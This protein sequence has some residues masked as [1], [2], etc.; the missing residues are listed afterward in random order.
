[1]PDD[2]PTQRTTSGLDAS[3]RRAGAAA[4]LPL[5]IGESVGPYKLVSVLGSGGFGVVYL[6]ER[7]EPYVQRVALKVLL[8]QPGISGD[9][10]I[11]RFEQERQALALMS[12][13]N[14]AGVLDAGTAQRGY[15]FFVMELVA[16]EPITDYCDRRRLTI[17][18]RLGLFVKVCSAVQHAHSKGV[19]HRDL[20]PS[21]VLVT[22]VQGEAVPKVIDFGV[23]KATIPLLTAKTI[24]TEVGRLIGTPEYMSPE[25]A[26]LTAVDI[27]TRTDVYS[28]GVMLYELLSG[29]LPFDSRSLRAAGYAEIQR[30]IREVDP[31]KPS[32]RLTGL[33]DTAVEVAERRRQGRDQLHR[34]LAREL[35]WIP[36][37]AMRKEREHRY[38]TPT[39]LADDIEN[40][41]AGRPLAAG[42][43]S[44]GYRLRKFVRRNRVVV[45]VGGVIAAVLVAATG[46]SL[47]FAASEARARLA[48]DQ[49]RAEA[50]AVRDFLTEDL[51]SPA[52]PE[53]DRP[54][55]PV[56]EL[57]DRA[58][59]DVGEKFKSQPAIEQRLRE[60]LGR[61]YLGI[62]LPDR[63]RVQLERARALI[64]PGAEDAQRRTDEIDG[65]MG[66][67][68]YRLDRAGEAIPLLEPVAARMRVSPGPSDPQTLIVLNQLAGAYKWAG[69]LDDAGKLY[70]EVVDGR[71]RTLGPRHIDTIIARKNLALVTFRTAV[72]GSKIASDGRIESGAEGFE[73]ALAEYRAIE[74]DAAAGLGA[75]HPET[76][77]VRAEVAMTLRILGRLDEAD[78]AY[79]DL[80]PQMER[81]LGR[82]HWRRLDALVNAARL[83][84][85]RQRWGEGRAK[86]EEAYPLLREGRGVR[87][88]GTQ[89]AAWWLAECLEKTGGEGWAS[90]AAA[91]LEPLYAELSPPDVDPLAARQTAE[92]LAGIWE[93]AGDAGKSGEWAIKAR[94]AGP[95]RR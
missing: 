79:A 10:V 91:I 71:T 12:H 52:D 42:P 37:K 93:R 81:K 15:P 22:E 38:R 83:D 34:E 68:L 35:D 18:Q 76:L 44:A 20:K 36:L 4:P 51:L 40:Y 13:P 66:E 8:A 87:N 88:S 29:A 74:P 33:G 89:R 31:P 57:L 90:E 30:I 39:E 45:A 11:A 69:R 85:R 2:T 46:V 23:A 65:R 50:T 55:I 75:E 19:I 67:V 84:M 72:A 9:E 70:K 77:A 25:Q 7:R 16:G 64:P 14:I 43:E 86:L 95:E 58:E 26:D 41:L 28:L 32:T 48:A 47:L 60:T 6:A 82:P 3:P 27:D 92:L 61:T 17:R 49:A 59:A 54:D 94:G 73:R 24:F 5:E 1:M 78:A 62:G 56:R 53:R 80:L 63:A 21:N